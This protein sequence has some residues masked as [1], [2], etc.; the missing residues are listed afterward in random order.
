MKLLSS[1]NWTPGNLDT[2]YCQKLGPNVSCHCAIS[3]A[4]GFGGAGFPRVS[5]LLID[6]HSRTLSEAG[7]Q[8]FS[9]NYSRMNEANL[10]HYKIIFTRY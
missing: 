2:A 1:I 5:P 4:T 3:Q 6:V 9:C 8:E 7:Q 10:C